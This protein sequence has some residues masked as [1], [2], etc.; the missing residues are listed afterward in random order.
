MTKFFEK[1]I[2]FFQK[3]FIIIIN[4]RVNCSPQ[5]TDPKTARIRATI[6]NPSYVSKTNQ[7]KRNYSS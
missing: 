6:Q 5:L 1:S 2:A 3:T 4:H 7:P